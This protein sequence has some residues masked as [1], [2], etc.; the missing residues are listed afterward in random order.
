M[1][2]HLG[3]AFIVEFIVALELHLRDQELDRRQ[4]LL[5]DLLQVLQLVLKVLLR[6]VVDLN[7]LFVFS[8][9]KNFGGVE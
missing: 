8:E 3:D 6:H 5:L 7:F 1:R 4:Q 2:N 9:H